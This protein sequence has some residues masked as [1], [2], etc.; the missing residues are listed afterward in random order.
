[1]SGSLGIYLHL[2]FCLSK[3]NYCDF[4]SFGG[5]EE[6]IARYVSELCGR[7]EAYAPKASEHT[8]DTVYFGGGTPTLVPIELFEKIFECLRKNYHIADS[9]EISCE[10][11]PA[12]CTGEYLS[13][14]HAMGVNRLSIGLQSTFEEE[15]RLLGR[16][17]GYSDFLSTFESARRVGF[18][19]VSVDLMYALPSQTIHSFKTSLERL[20]SLSPEHIS[21]YGLKIEEGT[22]FYD[23]YDS[24][25]L[26]SDDEQLEMYLMLSS[27]LRENGYNKYEISNFSRVGMES[28]HNLK[29]WSGG[30]YLGFGVAAH[31][32]FGNERFGNSRDM[33]GFL[34]GRDIVS[35]RYELTDVERRNEYVM[36]SLRLSKGLD[37]N[38][39][40]GRFGED[41]LGRYPNL[42]SY[43]EKGFMTQADGRLAFTDKGFFVS[44]YI[45]S[46]LI[47]G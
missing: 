36:L 19:N 24:L 40:R 28:K 32:F 27:Y 16:A 38:E 5:R 45:I 44:N 21:A 8:V 25:E 13:S 41:L 39:F 11:N 37:L 23:R 12:S 17:H 31:S 10:C 34:E 43:I 18:S 42:R 47:E 2:P 29:Y 20:V 35:E 4:C 1:M 26:P 46:E 33:E 30:E 3:C 14:L 15:L 6:D 22:P 9:A 7:I